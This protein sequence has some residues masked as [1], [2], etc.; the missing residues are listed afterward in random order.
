LIVGVATTKAVMWRGELQEFSNVYHFEG[1]SEADAKL[2]TTWNDL[3]GYEKTIHTTEVTFKRLRVWGP[4]DLGP[5]ASETLLIRDETGT[6]SLTAVPSHYKELAFLCVWPL[7][8]YGSRNRPQ[9]LRKWIHTMTPLGLTGAE[10]G[11]TESLETADYAT[12]TSFIGSITNYDP[13]GVSPVMELCSR[14]GRTPTGAGSV[15]PYLE[16]RQLGR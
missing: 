7:G 11:G 8:R 10:L 16:H 15:Y 9:F 14:D 13:T 2:G 6:G 4:T 5:G 1:V 3:V 12:L